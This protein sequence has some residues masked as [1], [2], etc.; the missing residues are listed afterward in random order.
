MLNNETFEEMKPYIR[1]YLEQ[2]GIRTDRFFRCINPSHVDSKASMKLFDD[3]KVYCFGCGA[4]YDLFGAIGANEHLDSKEAFK[5]ATQ[6]Y[7]KGVEVTKVNIQKPKKEKEQRDYTKAYAIWHKNLKDNFPATKYLL[8]RGISL[9]T[10]NKFNLGYNKFCFGERELDA[11]IIP[12][13]KNTFTARN[14]D[15][16]SEIRHYKPKNCHSGILNS[17]ALT[18]SQDHCI[19][20]EG[21]FDCLS[22]AEA[23]LNAISLG[24]IC[25]ISK[26]ESAE[27]DKS[28]LFVLALDNDEAGKKGA[29]K[30]KEYFDENN[31]HYCTFDNFGFKDPNEALT[32]IGLSDF[33]QAV[34]KLIFKEKQK[35]KTEE[36][37]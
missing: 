7:V 30:L 17:V 20:A 23:G 29:T 3:N 27:K 31:M 4:C 8:D 9:A 28:K 26:F 14:I 11:I 15:R 13:N 32:K 33:G 22:F 6:Y 2:Q 34:K 24:S 36:L 37:C 1:D 21:E 10:A 18:N 5:K 35:L 19:I 16:T 25:N 12:I